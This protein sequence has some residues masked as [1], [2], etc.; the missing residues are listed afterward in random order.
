MTLNGDN[1]QSGAEVTFE[2][3]GSIAVT[4][5]FVDEQ[6]LRL[7]VSIGADAPPGQR[8]L[9]VT[10]P[11]GGSLTIQNAFEVLKKS[12]PAPGDLSE[13]VFFR[14]WRDRSSHHRVGC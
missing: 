7:T 1:Y 6:T 12:L 10:N 3:A 9:V 4:T 14:S 2:P 8:A 13:P 5:Q 11:D